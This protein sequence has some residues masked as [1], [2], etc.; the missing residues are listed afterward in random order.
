MKLIIDSYAWIE[1]FLGNPLGE[2]V[3]KFVHNPENEIL[4]NI[5]NIAEISSYFA[6]N[7]TDMTES[8]EILISNSSIYMFDRDFSKKAGFLHAEIRK[9]IKDFGLIDAF[10]LLTARE[11]NA[12]ILTG[13]E[14]FRNFKEVI[15]IK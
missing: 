5:L 12:K 11:L 3:K 4:T 6:R 10:V 8:Y 13:D 14:H 7:N 9:K 2:K 15:M 1:Y